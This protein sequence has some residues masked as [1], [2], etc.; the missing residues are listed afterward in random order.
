MAMCRPTRKEI[1]EILDNQW[2]IK[3]LALCRAKTVRENAVSQFS[4]TMREG[5]LCSFRIKVK[6]TV[7]IICHRQSRFTKQYPHEADRLTD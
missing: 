4:V 6:V 5:K 1:K 7:N 3:M 2:I